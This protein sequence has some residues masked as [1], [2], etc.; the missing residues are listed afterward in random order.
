MAVKRTNP[1][2]RVVRNPK[3]AKPMP[4]ILMDQTMA[5][6][7]K[8]LESRSF[9]SIDE[10]NAYLQGLLAGG[11]TIPHPEPETPLEQ[12]QELIYE[13]HEAR[14]VKKR[15]ELARQA[16]TISPDCAD[17]YILLA[18]QEPAPDKRL[19]LLEQGMAAGQRA[20]GA[21]QFAKWEGIFWGVTETR[22]YMRACAGVG[23]LAWMLGQRTR[24]IELFTRM[25]LLN[26][27]DNQGVRYML[28][29]CLL[30]EG[31]DTGL[32]KLLN[33]YKDDAAAN[34]AY[35]KALLRFRILGHT[36]RANTTLAKAITANPFIPPYLLGN[37]PMPKQLPDT[38]GFGD[39]S[40][41]IEYVAFAI[42]AWEQTP[43][44]LDWL[45]RNVA[46]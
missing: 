7:T 27:S 13:A 6:V 34:W 14:S 30:E 15:T 29:N 18:E 31:D 1:K 21:D 9:E 45:R 17:A 37:K 44:A 23:E 40:E 11:G 42:R 4:R 38:I 16:L 35:S 20:I 43:G 46:D 28:T 25:L 5:D 36:A 22:P 24:A 12:A 39:E 32:A 2:R 8:L 41:A 10:A 3:S 26:P 19:D 33:H